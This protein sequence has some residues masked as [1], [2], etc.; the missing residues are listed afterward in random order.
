VSIEDDLFIE[1]VTAAAKRPGAVRCATFSAPFSGMEFWLRSLVVALHE[2]DDVDLVGSIWMSHPPQGRVSRMVP[3]TLRWWLWTWWSTTS[4]LRTLRRRNSVPDVAVLNHVNPLVLVGRT[5]R[6][7]AVVLNLDA[8]PQLTTAMAAHYLGRGARPA[9]AERL[10][11][12]VYRFVFRRAACIVAWSELV[13]RSLVDDYGVDES[14]VTVVPNGIDLAAWQPSDRHATGAV[15]VLFVG[16]DF[17]RKGGGDLLAVAE[18][19]EMSNV[20]F[21]VVT[22]SDVGAVPPNVVVHHGLSSTSDGLRDL[23]RSASIF[24]LPTYADMSP[25][26]IC[27]AMAMGLAVIATDVGA[28]GEMVLEG[29][30]GFLI[31]PGDLEALRARLG[32][33]VDSADLRERM[34]RRARQVVE[35]SLDIRENAKD[36]VAVLDRARVRAG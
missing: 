10:K 14:C 24:V 7:T 5:S 15:R 32:E 3:S 33:L 17:E 8:T 18:S 35:D 20:E 16:A 23:Y 1:G 2:R 6:R 13:R 28:L 21:H 11:L 30:T 31:E 12:R 22:K 26:V 27:E 25:N 4:G 19:L 36:F 29:E 34:G 9:W